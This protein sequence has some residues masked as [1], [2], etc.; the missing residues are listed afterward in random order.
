MADHA[1]QGG[2]SENLAEVKRVIVRMAAV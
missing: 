2:N 1:K